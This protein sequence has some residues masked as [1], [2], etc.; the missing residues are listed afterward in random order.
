MATLVQAFGYLAVKIDP[1]I[2][3]FQII[4]QFRAVGASFFDDLIEIFL[5]LF[6]LDRIS[7]FSYHHDIKVGQRIGFGSEKLVRLDVSFLQGDLPVY[8]PVILIKIKR[9][10]FFPVFDLYKIDNRNCP[11]ALC[12][13]RQL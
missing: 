9:L 11:A 10:R 4:H 13:S 7:I 1:E 5:A 8:F 6:K 3:R 2:G 12:E